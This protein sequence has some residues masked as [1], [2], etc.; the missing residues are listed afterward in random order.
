MSQSGVDGVTEAS[1]QARDRTDL[2]RDDSAKSGELRK[3]VVARN[4]HRLCV[5]GGFDADHPGTV[6]LASCSRPARRPASSIA[7]SVR[8]ERSSGPVRHAGCEDRVVG[9]EAVVIPSRVRLRGADLRAEI[10]SGPGIDGRR[11]RDGFH[12]HVGG[13]AP[14]GGQQ[15]TPPTSGAATSRP[16]LWTSNHSSQ[17]PAATRHRGNQPFGEGYWNR[18]VSMTKKQRAGLKRKTAQQDLI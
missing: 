16:N 10:T 3:V 18:H 11:G 2:G 5:P 6:E 12:R 7:R 14:R 4:V 17:P 15:A 9:I 8:P 1:G 13:S